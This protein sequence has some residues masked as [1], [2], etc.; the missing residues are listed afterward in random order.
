MVIAE[1]YEQFERCTQDESMRHMALP[2][3]KFQRVVADRLYST[4]HDGLEKGMEK[5]LKMDKLE[6]ARKLKSLGF[7]R[8]IVI[9]ATKPS[10][11]IVE[12]L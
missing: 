1:A 12:T 10:S 6:D 8:G 4:E 9:K 7:S 5:S 2:R 11:E 3:E